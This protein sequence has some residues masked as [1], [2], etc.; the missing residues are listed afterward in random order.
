M[1]KKVPIKAISFERIRDEE[2]RLVNEYC[3]LR[4]DSNVSQRN[5]SQATGLAQSTVARLEKN[6]HSASLGNFIKLLE[7]IGY[8]LEIKND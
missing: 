8:H 6:L 3:K 2:L 1:G 4:Q 5:I 7:V